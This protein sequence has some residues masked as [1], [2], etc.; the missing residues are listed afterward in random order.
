ML[1]HVIDACNAAARFV[2]KQKGVEIK[3]A[4]LVPE[5]DDITKSFKG[6]DI[7]EGSELDVLSRY[8][9]AT[10]IYQPDAIVRV[11]GDCWAMASHALSRSI[12]TMLILSQSRDVGYVTNT[13][14]HPLFDREV[15]EGYD[16]QVIRRDVM[17]WLGANA[18]EPEDREH[19]TTF[20]GKAIK[21]RAFPCKWAF[22]GD[23]VSPASIDT[24]A[25]YHAV[26]DAV[27]K[28]REKQQEIVHYDGIYVS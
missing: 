6:I 12:K 14:V 17:A 26:L 21:A 16:S 11:T 28:Q 27:S 4:L 8:T 5:G 3:V 20:I 10:A 2:G 7:V 18:T 1:R 23:A 13:D 15:L 9:K 24:P 25:Q 22:L 19:V